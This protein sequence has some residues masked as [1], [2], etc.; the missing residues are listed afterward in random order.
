MITVLAALQAVELS[1]R[2]AT[3][4]W[5]GS[6]PVLSRSTAVPADA[7]NSS[8]LID[9]L[10]SAISDCAVWDQVPQASVPNACA[11]HS[12]HNDSEVSQETPWAPGNEN[13]GGLAIG[14]Q[15]LRRISSA[16]REMLLAISADIIALSSL[17]CRWSDVAKAAYDELSRDL[18]NAIKREQNVNLPM[19]VCIPQP[20]RE[21][22]LEI[23]RKEVSLVSFHLS[24][25]FALSSSRS[26]QELIRCGNVDEIIA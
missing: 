21:Y 15:R 26:V 13:S 18:Q 17:H 10:R 25:I 20:A 6:F 24:C 23:S 2:N 22:G 5:V 1:P 14:V 12:R 11:P 16:S 7:K 3:Y 8:R 9:S 19:T 4:Q